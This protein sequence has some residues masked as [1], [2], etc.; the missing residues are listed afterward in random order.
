M[1]GGGQDHS[2]QSLRQLASTLIMPAWVHL[3]GSP[4]STDRLSLWTCVCRKDW[5]LHPPHEQSQKEN[6][7]L[8]RSKHCVQEALISKMLL[9]S[10]SASVW[11]GRE[12]PLARFI[13]MASADSLR[14]QDKSEI[15]RASSL[16][17]WLETDIPCCLPFGPRC[18]AQL[19]WLPSS[20]GS[21]ELVGSQPGACFK[22][23]Y[24]SLEL[25]KRPGWSGE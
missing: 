14:S 9:K 10:H 7:A 13:R 6:Q 11:V 5:P 8:G 4:V 21:P 3:L 12:N 16:P 25:V 19:F 23:F 22:L 24:L 18:N 15:L 20:L 1:G 17:A 2:L